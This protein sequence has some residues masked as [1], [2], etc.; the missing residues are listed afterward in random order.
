MALLAHAG[1][2]E[3][4]VVIAVVLG[5]TFGYWWAWDASRGRS[6]PRLVAWAGAATTLLLATSP[7]FESLAGRSFTGHMV[8]HLMLIAVT[9]PLLALSEP[10]ATTRRALRRTGRRVR[11][12]DGERRI[13]RWWRGVGPMIA[14][15]LFV[16]VLF[17]THLTSIYDRALEVRLVHDVE[18]VAYLGSAV[19]L[20]SVIRSAGQV[21]AVRRVGSVFAV[22]AGSALL[23]VVLLS[24]NAPLV[25]TYETRL[26]TAEAL[27]DQR[28]AASLMWVGGMA[29][30]LPLLVIAFWRWASTEQ[31][32][33]HQR[34]QL[35]DRDV[36]VR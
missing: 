36:T 23:G 4:V 22:I 24:A 17:V 18:H 1:V 15:G 8:Q 9:A 21:D 34:E 13:G 27:S 25:A 28:A 20:W 10:V 5:A 31:R 19:L 3:H 33:A 16:G 12:T 26:G 7:L 11:V 35:S 32:I 29:V 14:P 30:S 6:M 2:A